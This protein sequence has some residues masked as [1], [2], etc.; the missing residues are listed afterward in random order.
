VPASPAGRSGQ[1]PLRSA[2]RWLATYGTHK[3]VA[4]RRPL[5]RPRSDRETRR[6]NPVS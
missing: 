5:A 3:C 6:P 1:P 4:S 2:R